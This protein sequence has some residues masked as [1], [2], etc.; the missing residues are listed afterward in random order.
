VEE[1][2]MN[3]NPSDPKKANPPAVDQH[4]AA[5][6][7]RPA[8]V[9][10]SSMAGM[11]ADEHDTHPPGAAPQSVQAG[12][13]PDRF[14][15]KPIL[16]VPVIIVVTVL[17]GFAIVSTLFATIVGDEKPN[18]NTSAQAA[19][20]A[21]E[22]LDERMARIS[23]TDP[24]APVR[25]PRLESIQQVA[26]TP[27][28]PPYYRSKLPIPYPGQSYEIYPQDLRAVNFIDPTKHRKI[29]I[30]TGYIDR[31]KGV[32]FVPIA[33]AMAMILAQKKLPA[34]KADAKTDI[35]TVNHTVISVDRAKLSNAGRGG[36]SMPSAVKKEEKPAGEPKPKG[37]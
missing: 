37:H 6:S 29:L 19:A 27:S 36:P 5:K 33:D 34:R 20:I 15:V 32:A 7:E 8:N 24:N 16:Y 3:P 14:N 31:D 1:T 23:S 28:D 17:V 4:G 11:G 2:T 30:E 35:D 9:V 13:E 10:F 25:Q 18:A 21:A 26:N 22:P 12:H